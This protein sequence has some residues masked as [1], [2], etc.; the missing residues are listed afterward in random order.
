MP[1]API[2]NDDESSADHEVHE[3]VKGASHPPKSSIANTIE[4]RVA[5]GRARPTRL[6][7]DAT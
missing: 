3:A 5:A 6:L 2:A 1:A 7:P 4:R